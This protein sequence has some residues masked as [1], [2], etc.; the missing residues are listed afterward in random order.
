MLQSLLAIRRDG[1][2]AAQLLQLLPEQQLVDRI[3]L[4]DQHAQA[5]PG[6]SRRRLFLLH[7]RH[8][9][10]LGEQ[11]R[12]ADAAQMMDAHPP[13][14]SFRL[15][16]VAAIGAGA[17]PRPGP[18]GFDRRIRQQIEQHGLGRRRIRQRVDDDAGRPPALDPGAQA[19]CQFPGRRAQV[20]A[21]RQQLDAVERTLALLDHFQAQPEAEA[22]AQADLADHAQAAV[23]HLAEVPADRQAQAGAADGV[24]MAV[25]L[26]E[27]LEQAFLLRLGN[28][29]AGIGHLPLQL[30]LAIAA[31]Q[32]LQAQ[33]HPT[34]I[35]ELQGIAEQVVENLPDPRRV[36][37]QQARQVG[38]QAGVKLQAL[39]FGHGG[40][41][42]HDLLGQL[43]RAELHLLQRHLPGLD[44]RYVEDVADQLQ[45]RRG[46]ALDGV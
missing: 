25:G 2:A 43:Q 18:G 17:D 37:T 45:Q 8:L 24:L 11:Q 29:H 16:L 35:G 1:H 33:H 40:M 23:H 20:D 28:T 19:D 36:A 14:L 38:I 3:V 39:V 32:H 15:R 12:L 7:Q 4:G 21:V 31:F 27:R 42:A 30:H 22:A 26:V 34:E 5:E 44:L 13:A 9:A 10:A 6:Q 46:R 41:P